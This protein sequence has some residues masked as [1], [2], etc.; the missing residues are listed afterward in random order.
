MLS[1]KAEQ[2]FWVVDPR[3]DMSFEISNKRPVLERIFGKLG[4]F[5]ARQEHAVIIDPTWKTHGP[6]TGHVS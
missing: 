2:H 3:L 5:R 6:L 4:K 1:K